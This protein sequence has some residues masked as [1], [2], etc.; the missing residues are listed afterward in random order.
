MVTMLCFS[1]EALSEH[2]DIFTG[3]ICKSLHYPYV[4]NKPVYLIFV[5]F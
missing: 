1:D 4:Y 2:K 3:F 5:R